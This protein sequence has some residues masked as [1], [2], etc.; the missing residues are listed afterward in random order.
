[1]VSKTPDLN[2]RTGKQRN[3][4]NPCWDDVNRSMVIYISGGV[5]NRMMKFT[6]VSLALMT[7]LGY[8]FFL[9]EGVFTFILRVWAFAYMRVYIT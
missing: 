3:K 5:R 2:P 8:F 7:N 4:L 1:M 6:L 9:R